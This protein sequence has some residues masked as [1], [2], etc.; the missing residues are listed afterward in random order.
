MKFY[1]DKQNIAFAG[2]E[3]GMTVAQVKNM[4][5]FNT[6]DWVI[7][8]GSN[9]YIINTQLNLGN[10]Y[11]KAEMFFEEGTLMCV[12]FSS[13]RKSF[14]ERLIKDDTENLTKII[15]EAYGPPTIDYGYPSSL[16]PHSDFN[17]SICRW[18]IGRKEISVAIYGRISDFSKH[19][20]SRFGMYAL[21]ADAKRYDL[22]YTKIATRIPI[23]TSEPSKD[24]IKE[25]AAKF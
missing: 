5:P 25:A 2:A 11:Y 20:V 16:Y 22:W 1:Q 14:Y 10:S 12:T 8:Y 13:E 19:K 3:F 15:L 4:A 17:H 18:E 7:P 23:K 9:K 6:S 24:P 21:I